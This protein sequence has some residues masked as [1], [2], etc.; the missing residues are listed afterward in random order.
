MIVV[1]DLASIEQPDFSGI[2]DAFANEALVANIEGAVA[3]DATEEQIQ[4]NKKKT[5]LFNS[6]ASIEAACKLHL[7]AAVLANNH[8]FDLGQNLESSFAFFRQH[9]VAYCGAGATC[10]DAGEAI[11]LT[12]CGQEYAILSFCW[13][14][15]GGKPA[16]NQHG[17]TNPLTKENIQ[18]CIGKAREQYR[19]AKIIAIMHWAIELEKYPEPMHVKQARWAIDCGADIVIG[20]HPHRIQMVDEYKGKSIFYSIGNFYIEEGAYFDGRL[21]YPECAKE[22]MAVRIMPDKIRVL[23]LYKRK[24][25]IVFTEEISFHEAKQR[26]SFPTIDVDY[27][28]WFKKNRVKKKAIPVFYDDSEIVVNHMKTWFLSARALL[29]QALLALGL[30]RGRGK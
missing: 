24:D 22:S 3:A 19:N 4:R 26:F 28:H 20:H 18:K 12:D 9:G 15:T 13:D 16:T 8:V 17:G 23:L 1:G 25:Q 11:L 10:E 6:E 30:K 7:K 21:Q 2:A 27:D 5:I 14:V 29:I